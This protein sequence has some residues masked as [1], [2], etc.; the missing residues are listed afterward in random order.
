LASASDLGEQWRKMAMRARRGLYAAAA[1]SIASV[2][3]V[4]ARSPGLRASLSAGYRAFCDPSLLEPPAAAPADVCATGTI[5][6]AHVLDAAIAKDF[7]PARDVDLDDASGATLASL[8]LPDLPVP[9]TRRAM[10]FVRFFVKNDAGRRAFEDR[11]R[12]SGRYRGVVERALREAGLPEDLL[13]LAAVESGFNP[14]AVSP[15]G[16]AGLFQFMPETGQL[17]GL[18]QSPFVD[19]RRSVPRSSEAAV[20]HLRDLYERL[21]RWDLALAA[22]NAG[23][24][25]VLRA[26]A[27]AEE[28]QRQ[29]HEPPHA[30]TFAD[31][32][33]ARLVPDETANYVPQIA[34]FALVAAN[35]SRFGFDEIEVS[36]A[37]EL[38]ELAVPEGTRL[39]TIARAAGVSLDTIREDNPQLL[40]DRVPPTG[41]DYLL[42]LPADRVQ[43][44][45]VTLPAYLAHEVLDLGEGDEPLE[46][47]V[48]AGA[49]LTADPL[50]RRPNALGRNRLPDLEPEARPDPLALASVAP[51][52][53]KLPSIFVGNGVGWQRPPLE[54]FMRLSPGGTPRGSLKGREM[55]IDKALAPIL[56]EGASVDR[57]ERFRVGELEV[58]LRRDPGAP[59]VSITTARTLPADEGGADEA[60]AGEDRHT[61]TVPV[62][63]LD[64]GLE[65]A[66]A[67]LRLTDIERSD[68]SLA[69]LRRRATSGRRRALD[70]TPY[71]PSWIALSDALFPAGHPLEGML[72][73]AR[74]DP[75]AS[76][77]LRLTELLRAERSASRAS[78]LLV[79]DVDRARAEPLVT[80]AAGTLSRSTD[81][82]VPPHPSEE[83]VTVEQAVPSARALYGWIAPAEGDA[84]DV[85]MRVTFEIL[86]S[87]KYGRLHAALVDRKLA[88]DVRGA[89]DLG[90]RA[91]V[92]VLEIAPA[93]PHDVPEVEAAMDAAIAALAKDG[94]TNKELAIA[95]ALLRIRL[96]KEREA[97]H[98]TILAGAPLSANGARI[99]A[100]LAPGLLDRVLDALDRVDAREVRAMA[101]RVLARDHRVVVTTLPRST[102]PQGG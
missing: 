64:V 8:T 6:A 9:I 81:D 77:D 85:A 79:G 45:M 102:M 33:E 34:A 98:G 14:Q 91:S 30:P 96:E 74:N 29:A 71:G 37:R 22:Y 26:I 31:L 27:K 69:V 20:A 47:V 73:G 44:A 42:S 15:A 16:A 63:D 24:D 5:D 97:E 101:R 17:Y 51:P 100:A 90:P 94:P 86:A 46:P 61:T 93:V 28:L 95:K 68:A 60:A 35:R 58:A 92:A 21:H 13:W 43:Q 57:I 80:R 23:Y 59:F 55:A 65:L 87:V 75:D 70:A 67:R 82:A 54:A 36:P 50:P 32:A 76:R 88:A 41:G 99:R 12:R 19:E 11:F 84:N 78:I 48:R 10:R 66:L 53:A 62:R 3:L 4:G 39:R 2:A 49:P 38:A 72:V 83:R 89:L 40:R 56:P 7:E 52:D 25:G 1:L 18:D